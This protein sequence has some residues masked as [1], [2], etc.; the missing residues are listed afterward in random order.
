M[1]SPVHFVLVARRPMGVAVNQPRAPGRTKGAA[2]RLWCD[3]H[4]A[5]LLG[6]LIALAYAPRAAD[7]SCGAFAARTSL[8]VGM[9]LKNA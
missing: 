4:D 2:D 5:H 6:P 8:P 7:E 3:I 1:D 9:R